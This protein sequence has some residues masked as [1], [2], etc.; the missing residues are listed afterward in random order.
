V[1]GQKKN[2]FSLLF[3]FWVVGCKKALKKSEIGLG[4]SHYFY[5]QPVCHGIF[6]KEFFFNL[7]RQ[8]KVCLKKF[9]SSSILTHISIKLKISIITRIMNIERRKKKKRESKRAY[10][11]SIINII[12]L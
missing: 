2:F 11:F 9:F 10:R 8:K 7:Q 12:S 3:F 6:F 5:Y 1:G 4:L